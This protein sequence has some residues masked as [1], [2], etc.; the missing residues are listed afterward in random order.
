[1]TG[2]G[3]PKS[4]TKAIKWLRLSANQ[5]FAAAQY[6]LANIYNGGMDEIG[7]DIV[8]AYKWYSVLKS[9]YE[10]YDIGVMEMLES[11]M[12]EKQ[13]EDARA[14]AKRWLTEFETQSKK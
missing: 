2:M 5:G 6:T 7:S 13:I 8:R 1:M 14:Q 4:L 9:R 11:R 3:V 10:R 12:T